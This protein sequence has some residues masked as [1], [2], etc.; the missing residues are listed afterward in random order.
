MKII[1]LGPPGSGKG[2]YSSRIGKQKSW[3][4]ISTGDILREEV[5]NNTEL[6]MKA[7][8]HMDSGGLVPDDLIIGMFKKRIEQ[9]DCKEGFILDGF[10]RTIAQAEALS[11]ITQIDVVINLQ[12]PEHVI[13]GKILARRTC[14]KCGNIYNIADIRFGPNNEYRMPPL[15]PEKEGIC[16]KCGGNLVSRNDETEDLIKHRLATYRE[17]TEPLEKYY[18]EK[19]LLKNVQVI[20]PPDIMVPKILEVLEKA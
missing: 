5:R 17:Q 4:H 13:I 2:T 20:G 12:V 16:D 6:G 10:P 14:E 1:F 7:K 11:G 9:D 19:Q 3:A 18:D 8:S 15:N